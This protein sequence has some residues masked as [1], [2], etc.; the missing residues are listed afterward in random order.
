MAQ[1]FPE[2]QTV[3]HDASNTI[4][5]GSIPRESNTNASLYLKSN[6]RCFYPNWNEKCKII[7]YMLLKYF[8]I[9]ILYIV[10]PLWVKVLCICECRS[11]NKTHSTLHFFLFYFF[12]FLKNKKFQIFWNLNPSTDLHQRIATIRGKRTKVSSIHDPKLQQ[13]IE[14]W[15]TSPNLVPC[16]AH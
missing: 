5:M 9:I 8:Q 6:A 12:P 13:C 1:I 10:K 2:A 4:I 7:H 14:I 15:W 16:R 3:E 11:N